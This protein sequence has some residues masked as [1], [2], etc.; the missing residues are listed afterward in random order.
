MND[1]PMIALIIRFGRSLAVLVAGFV[2]AASLYLAVSYEVWLL[3]LGGLV[4]AAVL[5][6]LLLSYFELVRVISDMLL[7]K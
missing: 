4:A 1:Y 2:L 5:Y 7:P 3:G 6:V